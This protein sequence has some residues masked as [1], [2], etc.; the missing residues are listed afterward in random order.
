MKKLSKDFLWGLDFYKV[1]Y[2]YS[3][4]TGKFVAHGIDY[5]PATPNINQSLYE[6]TV[7]DSFVDNIEKLCDKYDPEQKYRYWYLGYIGEGF[8]DACNPNSQEELIYVLWSIAT[9]CEECENLYE[10]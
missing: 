10:D 4:E 2:E 3:P 8:S 1:S 7:D 5:Y 9:T 6:T